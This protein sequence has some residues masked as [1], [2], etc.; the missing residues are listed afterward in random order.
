MEVGESPCSKEARARS[1]T[2]YG[3]GAMAGLAGVLLPLPEGIMHAGLG[4]LE[5]NRFCSK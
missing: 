3:P 1:V 4:C 5:G 2:P